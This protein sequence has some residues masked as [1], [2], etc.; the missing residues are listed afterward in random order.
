MHMLSVDQ[1]LVR[2]WSIFWLVNGQ[3]TIK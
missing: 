3:I 1:L 2:G